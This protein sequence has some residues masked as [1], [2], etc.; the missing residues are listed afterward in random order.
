M[1]SSRLR[2]RPIKAAR[3]SAPCESN[4]SEIP[5][6]YLELPEVKF[7]RLADIDFREAVRTLPEEHKLTIDGKTLTIDGKSREYW[8]A[9]TFDLEIGGKRY[10][11]WGRVTG[12]HRVEGELLAVDEDTL[13]PSK[14]CF[15]VEVLTE[16]GDLSIDVHP[17]EPICTALRRAL[18]ADDAER[19]EVTYGGDTIHSG[20]F[21]DHGAEEGAKFSVQRGTGLAAP[22]P[23]RMT[24]HYATGSRNEYSDERCSMTLHGEYCDITCEDWDYDFFP[25][26]T[27]FDEYAHIYDDC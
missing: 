7:W 12:H 26:E 18:E 8:I 1:A 25:N 23:P 17:D 24:F 10:T 19:L 5:E 21:E 6:G 2:A 13:D 16:E 4:Y 20:T 3:K 9:D 15:E 11:G 27:R 14:E 22:Y